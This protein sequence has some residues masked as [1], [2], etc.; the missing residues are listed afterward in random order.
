MKRIFADAYKSCDDEYLQRASSAKP[1]WK[2][3]TTATTVLLLNNTLYVANVGDSR[4]IVCRHKPIEDTCVPLVLTKDHNPQQFDERMRIQKVGGNV[5]DG[6]ILGVL[7][8]SRSIGDGQ[9]KNH[10]VTCVPDMKKCTLTGDDRYAL[11]ACDGLWKTFT[12]KD[13]VEF[14]NSSLVQAIKERRTVSTLAACTADM[15]DY[16][17]TGDIWSQRWE[18]V[19]NLLSAEAVRRGSG[20][21][22]T[23]LI[24]P[25]GNW[26]EKL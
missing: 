2:D 6:R 9:Y 4:A 8:V 17:Y 22:V 3:G 15:P 20:D 14:V 7:E 21:N 12:N 1:S 23:V 16:V 24:L 10:G 25:F 13:A 11:I 5:K 19:C 18:Y 26:F